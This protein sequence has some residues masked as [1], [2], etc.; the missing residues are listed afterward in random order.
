M[1]RR[2]A[3]LGT[4]II[5]VPSRDH[6][7]YKISAARGE[8]ARTARPWPTPGRINRRRSARSSPSTDREATIRTTIPSSSYKWKFGD[9]TT[10]T[11]VNPT[12][13]YSEPQPGGRLYRDP[14]REGRPG[15]KPPDSVRITVTQERGGGTPGSFLT[16]S[17][18]PIPIR[19]AAQA[20]PGRSGPKRPAASSSIASSSRTGS[21]TTISG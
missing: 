13:T 11:G 10:G 8:A 16:T 15:N 4:A 17:T 9:G 7:I 21:G 20:R 3:A 5:Y 14:G 1:V 12:H 2:W 18:G 6:K 19:S